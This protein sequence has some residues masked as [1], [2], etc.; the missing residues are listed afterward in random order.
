MYWHNIEAV[1]VRIVYVYVVVYMDQT[2]LIECLYYYQLLVQQGKE[3]NINTMRQPIIYTV[4]DKSIMVHMWRSPLSPA[5]C[6][7]KTPTILMQQ[8]TN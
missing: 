2:I 6:I 3:D 5:T 1:Y 8:K 4:A 7:D